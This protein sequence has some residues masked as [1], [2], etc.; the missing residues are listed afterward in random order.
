MTSVLREHS[1]YLTLPGRQSLFEQALAK[2]IGPGDVVADLGC[3]VGVLGQAALRAGA[4]RVYGIDHSDALELARETARRTGTADRYICLRDSTYRAQLPEQV[5]LLLCDHV[6]FFGFD[7]GI[8]AML[9]D[10]RE[11]LLKPGGRIMPRRL[12]LFMAGVEAPAAREKV[13]R[14]AADPVPSELRWIHQHSVNAPFSHDFEPA[15]LL[16]D[17]SMLG[18]IVLTDPV[19]DALRYS[20]SLTATRPGMFHGLAAWFACE[21]AE[22]VWMTNS[23]VDPASIGRGNLFLPAA[24]PF[25]VKAG[26]TVTVDLRLRHEVPIISWTITPPGGLPPQRLSTWNSEM[27]KPED[28]VSGS[29]LPLSAN[30]TGEARRL[31][32]DLLDGTRTGAEIARVMASQHAH[33]MPSAAE[34]DRFVRAVLDADART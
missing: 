23:P 11:R 16:T 7:Y 17:P 1:E 3:G 10:A 14:W 33:L 22:D 30:Q 8:I 20:I 32:L 12:R 29:N 27:L 34:M 2:T 6:G 28:L 5:D 4:A 9:A 19:A 24:Q 26:E 21:L 25:A 13:D 31:V 18:E 15:D